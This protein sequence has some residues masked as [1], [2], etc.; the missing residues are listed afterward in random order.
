MDDQLEAVDGLQLRLPSLLFGLAFVAV[1]VLTLVAAHGGSGFDGTWVAVVAFAAI[2][3]A[4][5]ISV[6]STLVRPRR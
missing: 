2:G 3:V 4:G 1:A 6:L 5:V